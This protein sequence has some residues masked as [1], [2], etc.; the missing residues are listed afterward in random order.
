MESERFRRQS[1]EKLS[2]FDPTGGRGNKT[3]RRGRKATDIL[4][5]EEKYQLVEEEKQYS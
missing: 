5:I 4:E 2:R 1:P 3:V